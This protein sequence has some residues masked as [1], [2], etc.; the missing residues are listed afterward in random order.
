MLAVMYLAVACCSEIEASE[1]SKEAHE[2]LNAFAEERGLQS[3]GD[4]YRLVLREKGENGVSQL[5]E[6][7]KLR[8]QQDKERAQREQAKASLETQ[9]ESYWRQI[10][11]LRRERD[12]IYAATYIPGTPMLKRDIRNLE[13]NE[14]EISEFEVLVTK[15]EVQLAELK[16]D[17][18]SKK[19]NEDLLK[20]LEAKLASLAK[21]FPHRTPRGSLPPSVAPEGSR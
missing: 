8:K 14:M 4:A 15:L 11:K 20:Q 3:I 18:D 13:E 7:Y 16:G 9:I 2:A 17:M 10:R 21:K 5:E 12:V 6:Q 19:W 1:I